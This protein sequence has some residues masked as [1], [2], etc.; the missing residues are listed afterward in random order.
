MILQN[1][2]FALKILNRQDVFRV[3]IRFVTNAYQ[4]TS[5]LLVN[6][7]R[8][9]LDFAAPSVEISFRPKTFQLRQTIGQMISRPMIK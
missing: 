4:P 9:R 3:P 6:P 5:S 7:R 8:H 1:V 2:P